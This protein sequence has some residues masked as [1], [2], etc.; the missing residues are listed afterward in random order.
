VAIRDAL[1]AVSIPVV[2]IHLSN[3][4]RREPFRHHSYVSDIAI[5][6]VVGFGAHGYVMAIEAGARHLAESVEQ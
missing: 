3:I 1:L 2:E 5:G 6:Q 4:H